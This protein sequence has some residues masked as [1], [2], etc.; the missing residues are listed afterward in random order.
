MNVCEKKKKVKGK[1]WNEGIIRDQPWGSVRKIDR[2][3]AGASAVEK[4]KNARAAG[5]GG[6]GRTGSA[7]DLQRDYTGHVA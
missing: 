3:R 5:N 2:P 4:L 1:G 7:E 6:L